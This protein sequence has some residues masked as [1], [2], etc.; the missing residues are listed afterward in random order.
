MAL[1]RL[2]R[3]AQIT[4]PAELRKRFHLEEGDYLEVEAIED[5]NLHHT[6]RRRRAIPAPAH[7]RGRRTGEPSPTPAHPPRLPPLLSGLTGERWL[8]TFTTTSLRCSFRWPGVMGSMHSQGMTP[9]RASSVSP[10]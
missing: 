2:K 5:G 7:G 1:V 6:H 10:R 4:L 9:P 8:R 3:A